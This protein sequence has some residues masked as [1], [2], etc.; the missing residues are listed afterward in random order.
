MCRCRWWRELTQNSLVIR[1]ESKPAQ[2]RV[3]EFHAVLPRGIDQP[4]RS[5]ATRARWGFNDIIDD[6]ET[7]A[8][9]DSL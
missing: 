9:L 6:I 1:E 5:G 4:L 2:W 3:S 8:Q 7:I